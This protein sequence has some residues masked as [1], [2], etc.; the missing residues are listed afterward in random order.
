MPRGRHGR[1]LARPLPRLPCRILLHVG[2]T[3]GFAKEPSFISSL[4]WP[5]CHGC[6]GGLVGRHH[7]AQHL[8][9]NDAQ[10]VNFLAEWTRATPRQRPSDHHGG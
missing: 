8:G 2:I 6:Q 10:L 7:L 3:M 9:V 5:G 4:P 1:R